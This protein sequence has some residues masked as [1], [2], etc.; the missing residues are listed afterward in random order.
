MLA[1]EILTDISS[2]HAIG[3]EWCALADACDA[4]APGYPWWCLTWW[5]CMGRGR[6]LVVTVR[7]EGRLVGLAPFHLVPVG[8]GGVVRMLGHGVGS[9]SRILVSPGYEQGVGRAVWG[10]ALN[11]SGRFL[12]LLQYE[13]RDVD[14][15]SALSA[16]HRLDPS[17]VCPTVDS[18]RPAPA[19]QGKRLAR[20]LRRAE[21]ALAR[22]QTSFRPSVVTTRSGVS[23]F[24][25]AMIGLVSAAE[26]ARP[27]GNLFAGLQGEFTVEL[28]GEAADA[29]R[30]RLHLGW[31]GERLAVFHAGL[32]GRR[33]VGL[34]GHRTDPS[35]RDYS[36]GH[37]NIRAALESSREEGIEEVDLF[38]GDDEYKQFWADGSYQTF[39]VLAARSRP[40]LTAERLGLAAVRRLRAARR[41]A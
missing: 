22:D 35:M 11:R 25:S 6:L 15:I 21:S 29:G 13:V 40:G 33:S 36:P 14:A 26:A 18:T 8:P 24:L 31:V 19:L 17:E 23:E 7:D 30:L 10:A 34:W 1:T 39:T 5:R 32:L 9:V 12:Q 37:L 41:F 20:I 38:P 3:S 4:R 2:T 27:L 28:L 16:P